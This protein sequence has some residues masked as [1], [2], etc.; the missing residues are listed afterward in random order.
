MYFFDKKVEYLIWNMAEGQAR[1]VGTA[2]FLAMDGVCRIEVTITG[3]GRVQGTY[4]VYAL[5]GDL[6]SLLGEIT[7]T[8]G[9]GELFIKCDTAAL[10]DRRLPYQKVTGIHIDLKG[11]GYL[12]Q[13]WLPI[14]EEIR[15]EAGIVQAEKESVQAEKESVR[16]EKEIVREVEKQEEREQSVKKPPEKI[17]FQLYP[18]KWKQ[19]CTIYPIVHPFGDGRAYLSIEPRDFVVLQERFQPMV[20][21]SFLLHGFYHYRHLLLGRHQQG[22][23]VRYYLGVPGVF[24]EK[25]KAAA[26]FYGFESFEGAEHP[27]KEGDFGYYM[28]QVQ[29]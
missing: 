2:R 28:K 22:R 25:E 24:Y 15:K 18:S 14:V 7:M 21:N 20:E 19:L 11:E 4:P 5:S 26:V 23:N 9:K 27:T 12:E 3:C 8:N 13:R 1:G 29:I 17:G 16:T 6:K 10:G